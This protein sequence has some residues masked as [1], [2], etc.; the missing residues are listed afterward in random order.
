M[1]WEAWTT[2]AALA[3]AYGTLALT[4]VA[5]DLVLVGT[6][7]LLLTVGILTPA[8]LYACFG[9]EAVLIIAAL[10]VVAAGLRETR[11]VSVLSNRLL[12]RPQSL[13]TALARLTVPVAAASAFMNNTPLVAALVP[14]TKEW[15]ANNRLPV[16][17]LLIPLSY[18]T[19]LGG[20]CTLVGTS[21]NLVVN[22]LLVSQTDHPGL[23]LFDLAPVGVPC[24]VVGLLYLITIGRRLL[25]DRRPAL[26][27][28]DD[29]RQYTVEM[30]VEP[31]GGLVGRTIEQA[32]LRHLPG[33]FLVEIERDGQVLPAVAP[34]ERLRGN[35]RLVFA[36]V[37]A[38][39]VDLQKIRGLRPA[40]DQVFKLDSPRSDRCLIEAVVSDSCPLVDRTIRDGRF[41]TVY[42]AAVI[43]VARNGE[44]LPGKIGD[45]V[46][47]AGDILLLE[48]HPGFT[49]RYRDSRDFFLLSAVGDSTPPRHNRAGTAILILAGMV[50]VA[51]VGLLG[52]LNAAFL[53]AALMIVTGCCSGADARRAIDWQVLVVIGAALCLGRAVQNSGAATAIMPTVVGLAGGNPW[54]ALALIYLV[55]MI[56]TEVLTNTAA[57]ALVFPIAL[58]TANGLMVNPMP[59]VI[60][61]AIAASCGFATPFGYQTNL[62]VYGPG[63]YRFSDYL[64]VGAP[65]NL[66]VA[67]VTVA[68]APIWWPF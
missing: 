57:A 45:V 61:V 52:L 24:A 31:G 10:F 7:T 16:S 64:K 58:A 42:N 2:L 9:N 8:D 67:G 19:I 33:L 17:K 25:P 5:P 54:L 18:A 46:L 44:R 32:Q 23:R 66:L 13:T 20:L 68:L 65:L 53:A 27:Y 49:E 29:P 26:G 51:A 50:G 36:G 63:G 41:R 56:C 22:G 21:T 12:G 39:V 3:V 11:V 38:S 37:V 30:L 60:A 4:R 15:A 55:T 48:A 62:M 43:A 34:T 40:T 59:F 47:R 35:D 1:S 28:Q 14:V 6:V